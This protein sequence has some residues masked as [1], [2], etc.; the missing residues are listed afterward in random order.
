MDWIDAVGFESMECCRTDYEDNL[1]T[2]GY[3]LPNMQ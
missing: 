2:G 3:N 1:G